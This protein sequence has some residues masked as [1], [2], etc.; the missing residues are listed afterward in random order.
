VDGGKQRVRARVFREGIVVVEDAAEPCRGV[1]D[2]GGDKLRAWVVVKQT[3]EDTTFPCKVREHTESRVRWKSAMLT[4][5]VADS[6][7]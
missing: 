4:R 5:V 6:G 2:V 3:K 7:S 1:V